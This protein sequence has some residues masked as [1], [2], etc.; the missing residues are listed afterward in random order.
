MN[1]E[2]LMRANA[3]PL[4]I[5]NSKFQAEKMLQSHTAGV[6]ERSQTGIIYAPCKNR[7][8]ECNLFRNFKHI[9]VIDLQYD[10]VLADGRFTSKS[11][12]IFSRGEL[13]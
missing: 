2:I 11:R 6:F 4:Q 10:H 8:I 5:G 1:C 7:F 12:R 9:F 3:N 13:G